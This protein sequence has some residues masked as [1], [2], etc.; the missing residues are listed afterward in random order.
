MLS[1]RLQIFVLVNNIY[2]ADLKLGL[3]ATTAVGQRLGEFLYVGVE[4]SSR[5]LS[6][7]RLD[8]LE[9]GVVDEDVLVLRLNHVVALCTQARHVAV[10]VD[11][12]LM[13][14][15]L[16]HRVDDDER[17]RSA[18]AGTSHRTDNNNTIIIIMFFNKIQSST[19][20][21]HKMT[22]WSPSE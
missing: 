11:G 15:A 13:L 7:S 5:D 16:Q 8:G 6:V 4:M 21:F 17:T 19:I 20:N 14:H 12:P 9:E 10:D 22:F 3:H 2:I 18:D 1:F